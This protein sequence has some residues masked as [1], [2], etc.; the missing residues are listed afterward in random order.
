MKMGAA[1]KE[2]VAAQLSE[3]MKGKFIHLLDLSQGTGT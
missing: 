1:I 2:I 3:E